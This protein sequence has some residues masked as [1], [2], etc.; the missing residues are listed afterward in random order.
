MAAIV[1]VMGRGGGGGRRFVLGRGMAEGALAAA[2]VRAASAGPGGGRPP[3]PL[4][5]PVPVG[6]GDAVGPA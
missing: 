1:P 5:P 3:F 4:F 2:F 6:P